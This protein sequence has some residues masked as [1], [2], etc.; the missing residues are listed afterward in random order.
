VETIITIGYDFSLIL[1]SESLKPW[2]AKGFSVSHEVAEK[3]R[4]SVMIVK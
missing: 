3:A 4:N 1:A 2:F